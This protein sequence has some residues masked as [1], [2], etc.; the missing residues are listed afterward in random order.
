MRR[1]D[2]D[3]REELRSDLIRLAARAKSGMRALRT[4]F[5]VGTFPTVSM[6]PRCGCQGESG[7]GADI[8]FLQRLVT[9][10]AFEAKY[11][12]HNELLLAFW[13]SIG[14]KPGDFMTVGMNEKRT[15]LFCRV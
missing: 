5:V 1:F 14:F 6:R 12:A 15:A 4:G 13:S 7:L 8:A 2:H 11:G 10:P 3:L 9:K